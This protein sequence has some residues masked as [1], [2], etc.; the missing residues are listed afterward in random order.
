MV[1]KDVHAREII[2]SRGD[3][4]LEVMITLKNGISGKAAV[5]SGASTGMHEAM[6]LRDGD[7][8]RYCG[9]GVLRATA[10]VNQKIRKVMLGRSVLK[11][12][13]IDQKMI[14][15]DGTPNKSRLGANAILGVSLACARTASIAKRLPLYQYLRSMFPLSLK[16][17]RLPIPTF[18]ILNGGKHADNLLDVQEL[19]VIP[20]AIRK[21]RDRVRAGYEIFHTLGY[22][23]KEA[24]YSTNV[25]NEGG[26]APN[27]HSFEEA[28]DLVMKSIKLAGYQAGVDVFLGTDIGASELYDVKKQSYHFRSPRRVFS[29]DNMIDWMDRLLRRYPFLSVED[30]LDQDAWGGWKTLTKKF[31]RTLTLVGDDIFVTNVDR[32]TRGIEQGVANAILIKLNQ[33]GTVS[34]TMKTIVFAQ[35]N[36][37]KISISHRSGETCDD[38]IA[39][40][41]VAVNADFVKMGSTRGERVSKYNRL[42]EIEE[43]L[44]H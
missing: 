30:P 19:M 5:P 42:M 11:Q 1:I 20:S 10:H 32:L 21:F 13:E 6:E 36:Q 15:I 31:G 44:A 9:K 16:S 33:I 3:P 24:D 34:E 39:D 18:N 40:L 41:A 29:E 25:G 35:K 17:Y 27:V 7:K 38:F 26:Y 4:T 37:Y 2:D 8:K 12:E 14:A 43:S 22:V 23:L 28:L